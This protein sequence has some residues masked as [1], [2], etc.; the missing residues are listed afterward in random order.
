MFTFRPMCIEDDKET[1]I[2]FRQDFFLVS[3]GNVDGFGHSENYIKWVTER[4]ALF[5]DG[6][7]LV[8]EHGD[9]VGQIELQI[10][11]YEEKRIGYVHL[12]YL[13]LEYRDKGRGKEL[14][15]YAE[16]FFQ[17]HGIN[18]YQLRVSVTNKRAISFYEKHGL[19]IMHPE[20]DGKVYRMRK[21]I[22]KKL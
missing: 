5:P 19:E 21:L 12:F 9:L 11:E 2:Y 6:F 20:L 15:S 1:I 8:E 22:F 13:I 16:T 17:R 3:F 7:M 10:V 14:L 18:E 4:S